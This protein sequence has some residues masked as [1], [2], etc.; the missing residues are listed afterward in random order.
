[1]LKQLIVL[2]LAAVLADQAGQSG[3]QMQ[4]DEALTRVAGVGLTCA[5]LVARLAMWRVCDGHP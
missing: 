2:L 1:M 3:D 5:F 4:R